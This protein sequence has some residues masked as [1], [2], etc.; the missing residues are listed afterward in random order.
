M[1][2]FIV[3]VSELQNQS[4]ELKNNLKEIDTELGSL[5]NSLNSIT[6]SWF[7]FNSDKFLGMIKKDYSNITDLLTNTKKVNNEINS[8][9]NNITT[10][11]KMHYCKVDKPKLKFNSN[12]VSKVL[13]SLSN[14]KEYLILSEN[15][16]ENIEIPV[17]FE[18]RDQILDLKKEI[19]NFKNEIQSIYKKTN[20][21]SK[22]LILKISNAKT[23]I[24]LVEDI[25]ITKTN[26]S[27]NWN[28]VIN[29]DSNITNSKKHKDLKEKNNKTISYIKDYNYQDNVLDYSSNDKII[30]NKDHNIS[31]DKN[32]TD[33]SS[34]QNKINL[35][36]IDIEQKENKSSF[37]SDNTEKIIQKNI[38][39]NQKANKTNLFSQQNKI[40][41]SSINVEQKINESEFIS[42]NQEIE[43]NVIFNNDI[44]ED[45]SNF[46]N[47]S[48]VINLEDLF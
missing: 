25:E 23:N 34:Q 5:Y 18:Y 26:R 41:I 16:L 43:S 22:D 44:N 6:T 47:N 42:N 28:T 21:F 45:S 4:L 3:D 27:Y 11:V 10:L 7:D 13:E 17:E 32:K 9:C 37:I 24:K 19:L 1:Y 40:N 30:L 38:N 2:N 29:K 12:K 35:K 46:I 39:D 14:G 48:D 31:I 8:L 15:Q 36:E 20:D 33:L